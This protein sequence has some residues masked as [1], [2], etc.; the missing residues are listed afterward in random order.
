MTAR[1]WR[2]VM[3]GLLLVLVLKVLGILAFLAGFLIGLFGLD[4]RDIITGHFAQGVV[5]LI[6]VAVVLRLQR[7]RAAPPHR[8]VESDPELESDSELDSN[9]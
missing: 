5:A 1:T 4:G 8:E 7:K 2:G 6:V 3:V 9:A